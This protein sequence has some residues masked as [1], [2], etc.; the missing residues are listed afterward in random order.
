MV[1]EPRLGTLDTGEGTRPHT[2][3]LKP[4]V[5]KLIFFLIIIIEPVLCLVSLK[6]WSSSGLEV[7]REGGH[8]LPASHTLNKET[9]DAVGLQMEW[10]ILP[11]A[12]LQF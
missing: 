2:P 12:R 10:A 5:V 9:G 1:Q 11:A 6:A 7:F 8:A 3:Q 4:G